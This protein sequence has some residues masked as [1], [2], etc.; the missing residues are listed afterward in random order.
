[1]ARPH[2]QVILAADAVPPS[3]HVALQRT[4]AT[5]GFWPLAEALRESGIPDAD[6]FVVVLPEDPATIAGPL[7]ILF[8]R[9][10]EQPRATLV[11]KANGDA[12]E[13]INHPQSVPVTFFAGGDD[14]LLAGQLSALAATRT[15][16]DA[17]HRGL[18][19]SRRSGETIARRYVKQLRLASQ[20]Q[21]EFLPESLPRF[22]PI[23]FQALFRPVDYVSGDIYDVHRLDEDHVGIA[24]ADATGHGMPAALLT[25]YIKRALRGKEIE[26]GA[27]RILSPEEVLLRLNDDIMEA[28][29][30]ECPFV[31]ALYAVLNIRTYELT[32]ARGGAP[33]PIRRTAR[34]ELEVLVSDGGVVGVLPNSRF[35]VMRVQMQPGDSLLLYSD[36][37]ERIVAPEVS[38]EEGPDELR[39]AAASLGRDTRWALLAAIGAEE[40]LTQSAETATAVADGPAP[41]S[42]GRDAGDMRQA[43]T[44]RRASAGTSPDAAMAA[45]NDIVTTSPWCETFRGAGPAAAL[46]QIDGRQRAL[47]RMGYPLD[48]LTVLAVQLGRD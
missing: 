6:A 42:A 4:N 26:N 11:L 44:P 31:A 43:V 25:V 1:M 47:R 33:Y 41:W 12:V 2:I 8:D 45:A 24:L 35:E 37:L 5:A 23:S 18:V 27:Y 32:F 46:E 39:S 3:L 30:T 29:L 34:G 9:L 36:G 17:L 28:G 40:D 21:R 7:R 38:M 20:V 14:H 48:D 22:G 10:S 19:D 13:P 16:L 15:S